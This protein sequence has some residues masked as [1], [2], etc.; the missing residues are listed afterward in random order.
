MDTQPKRAWKP[1]PAPKAKRTAKANSKKATATGPSTP[2]P[3]GNVLSL[4][5]GVQ[6]LLNNEGTD[7]VESE[8]KEGKQVPVDSEAKNQGN[9]ASSSLQ[10]PAGHE[11]KSQQEK[12]T[13]KSVGRKVVEEA[14]KVWDDHVLCK[15]CKRF[16]S[17]HRCRIASKC[18]GTWQCCECKTKTTQLWRAFGSWPVQAFESL[19]EEERTEFYNKIKGLDAVNAVA[20]AQDMIDKVESH[21]EYYSDGGEYLPLSVWKARGFDPEAIA[22]HSL[23]EDIRVHAVLGETYRVKILNKGNRGMK[24]TERRNR[25]GTKRNADCQTKEPT[26]ENALPALPTPADPGQDSEADSSTSMSDSSSTSSSSSSSK[27]KKKSKKAKKAKKAKQAKK[28][29]KAKKGKKDKADKAEVEETAS[30]RKERLQREK[31]E[32]KQ[33]KQRLAEQCKLAA[34]MKKQ[35]EPCARDV[36]CCHGAF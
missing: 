28:A 16:V 23:P 22:K 30:E 34:L 4:L 29:K 19:S 33:H 1:K 27:H 2:A 32:E 17:V 6:T 9:A 35:S 13:H 10:E 14:P 8:A 11:A 5:T 20:E 31:F 36:Q 3:S 21:A 26:A 15:N 7:T 25:R 24:G 18:A 12:Q